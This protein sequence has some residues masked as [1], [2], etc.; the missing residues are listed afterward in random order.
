MRFS[1]IRTRK[2]LWAFAPNIP[3]GDFLLIAADFHFEVI[4][5]YSQVSE[6]PTVITLNLSNTVKPDGRKPVAG[7]Q[8]QR[9][10]FSCQRFFRFV[11]SIIR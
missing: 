11:D 3:R 9:K 1:S 2:W 5:R 6:S 4:F 10:E 8:N 7:N